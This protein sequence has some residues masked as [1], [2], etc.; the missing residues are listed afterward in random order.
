MLS[1]RAQ[2]KTE[3]AAEIEARFRKAWSRADV[4]PDPLG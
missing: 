3:L 2:G 1:L 4:P